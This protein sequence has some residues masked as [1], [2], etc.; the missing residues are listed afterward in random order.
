MG[1]DRP[2]R[3]GARLGGNRLITDQTQLCLKLDLDST[4]IYV[5]I[6]YIP[7][8]ERERERE[9]NVVVSIVYNR[10]SSIIYIVKLSI[11]YNILFKV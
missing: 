8:R 6:H 4:C 7:Q 3:G 5:F 2:A 10:E 9:R 1:G 11:I